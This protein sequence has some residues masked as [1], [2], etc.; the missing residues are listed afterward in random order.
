VPHDDLPV[1]IVLQEHENSFVY[2]SEY[3]VANLTQSA[4]DEGAELTIV[5][6]AG[7]DSGYGLSGVSRVRQCKRT[8]EMGHYTFVAVESPKQ[9]VHSSKW[10]TRAWTFQEALLSR[11]CLVFTETQCYFQCRQGHRVESIDPDVTIM[12]LDQ[13]FEAFPQRGLGTEAIQ[14]YDRIQ[15]YYCK[16]LSYDA[17]TLNAISGIFRAFRRTLKSTH[18]YGIPIMFDSEEDSVSPEDKLRLLNVSLAVGL[19]WRVVDC[20]SYKAHQW[21][22]PDTKSATFPSWTWA[23]YRTYQPKS[24]IGRLL[25]YYARGWRIVWK[26]GHLEL[27]DTIRIRLYHRSGVKMSL[28]EYIKHEDDY[29]AFHPCLELTSMSISGSVSHHGS[30]LAYFSACPNMVLYLQYHPAR[31]SSSAAT[32]VYVGSRSDSGSQLAFILIEPVTGGY[33]RRIGMLSHSTGSKTTASKDIG[34]GLGKLCNTERW[35]QKTFK[36]V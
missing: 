8:F 4:P 9:E 6:A 2:T 24:D 27:D 28:L 18:F 22:R 25:F 34:W 23:A 5:A 13:N 36:L 7:L 33:Y 30:D 32:A 12:P 16:E 11:R 35:H 1:P 20:R 14:I 26:P 15:E 17:D 29:S 3:S 21:Y 10:N 31:E 19:A